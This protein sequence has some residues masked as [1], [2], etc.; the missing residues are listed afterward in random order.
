MKLY[1]DSDLSQFFQ[2]SSSLLKTEERLHSMILGLVRRHLEMK[3]P[4]SILARLED[5]NGQ[6]IAVGIQTDPNR[7]LIVPKLTE[8]SARVFAEK[9]AD[10]IPELP[11]ANGPIPTVDVFS[12]KW[13]S[14][15]QKQTKLCTNLRLFEL[16]ELIPPTQPS[17][18]ARIAESK[19]RDII[20]KWLIEFYDEAIPHDPKPSRDELYKSIDNGISLERYFIW[21]VEEAPVSLVGSARE[22]DTEKWIAPVYTPKEFRGKGYGSALTAFASQRILDQGKVGMLFTDLANPISNGIYQKIGYKPLADFKHI[23]FE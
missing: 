15:K 14:L 11:G 1:L 18:F 12:A 8:A 3:K 19:D 13:A 6:L 2:N 16:N 4:M 5:E 22:T 17:G 10:K 21:E 7:T 23:G 20:F 9:L